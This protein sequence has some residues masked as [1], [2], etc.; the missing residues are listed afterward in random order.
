MDSIG[1]K[2]RKGGGRREKREKR[3]EENERG[4][5]RDMT[6]KGGEER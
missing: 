1:E 4:D 6:N 2:H 3:R 5:R